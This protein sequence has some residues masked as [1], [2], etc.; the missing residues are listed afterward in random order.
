[1]IKD[2]IRKHLYVD[3]IQLKGI[4]ERLEMEK[5]LDVI[6]DMQSF[7]DFMYCPPSLKS[8]VTSFTKRINF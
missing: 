8:L 7:S 5:D 3:Q 1:M 4:M 6:T 2:R